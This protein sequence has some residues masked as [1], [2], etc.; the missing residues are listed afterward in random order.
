[1]TRS[2]F[3]KPPSGLPFGSY[4]DAENDTPPPDKTPTGLMVHNHLKRKEPN[5]QRPSTAISS[6]PNRNNRPT[7]DMALNPNNTAPPPKKKS[8]IHI[9][10]KPMQFETEF[11]DGK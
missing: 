10:D 11:I 1:M 4:A 2:Y 9:A 3:A 6:A 8:N 5:H 7:P